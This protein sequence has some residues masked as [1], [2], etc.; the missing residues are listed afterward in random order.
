MRFSPGARSTVPKKWTGKHVEFSV[1]D[2]PKM[3]NKSLF[4]ALSNS[5][6]IVNACAVSFGFAARAFRVNRGKC[7]KFQRE[8][9]N[10]ECQD[11]CGECGR[12][13]EHR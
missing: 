11:L 2:V 6:P 12:V 13:P 9:H 10:C 7:A 4:I 5:Q 3:A 1:G 8:A